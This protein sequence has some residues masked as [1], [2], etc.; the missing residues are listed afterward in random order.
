MGEFDVDLTTVE[1]GIDTWYKLLPNDKYKQDG[2]VTGEI[3][4]CIEFDYG[5][6]DKL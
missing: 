6:I 5:E 2:E 4:L 1:N 3:K